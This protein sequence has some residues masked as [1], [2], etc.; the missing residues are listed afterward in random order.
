M[1]VLDPRFARAC[2]TLEEVRKEMRQIY[3]D[4]GLKRSE[5]MRALREQNQSRF[6]AS[7]RMRQRPT[8]VS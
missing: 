2:V 5:E 1:S 6:Q 8:R 7:L 4:S 3:P